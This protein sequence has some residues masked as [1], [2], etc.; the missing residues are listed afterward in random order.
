MLNFNLFSSSRSSREL[1]ACN[2]VSDKDGVDSPVYDHMHLPGQG[3]KKKKKRRHRTIFT[4]YQLDE[5]EKAFKDAHYPDVQTREILAMKTSLPEDRIQVWFQNR[6]AKWRKTEKT[7][8]RSSIMAE[9]G[10]YGAMVRHSLPLPETIVKSAKEGVLESSAPWLLSMY[11]K[12]IE[13]TGSK[14]ND[15]NTDSQDP[16][17]D[18]GSGGEQEGRKPEDFRSESIAALRARAMEYTAKNFPPSSDAGD[19]VIDSDDMSS[20][21]ERSCDSNASHSLHKDMTSLD[22]KTSSVYNS[23]P[24]SK[25][26]HLAN[27]DASND[28]EPSTRTPESYKPAHVLPNNKKAPRDSRLERNLSSP[29]SPL[30]SYKETHTSGNKTYSPVHASVDNSRS[31]NK[32]TS[33]RQDNHVL[34]THPSKS[35]MSQFGNTYLYPPRSSPGRSSSRANLMS[36][37]SLFP[38]PYS[39][40]GGQFSPTNTTSSSPLPNKSLHLP[41]NFS[42]PGWGNPF[43]SIF[44]RLGQ[45]QLKANPFLNTYGFSQLDKASLHGYR[46]PLTSGGGQMVAPD[47]EDPSMGVNSVIAL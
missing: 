2:D 8:G 11:R 24:S 20:D 44:P 22:E 9:Y 28:L 23:I 39:Y 32:V 5:L 37:T 14:S 33:G 6:R 31:S 16:D 29:A 40:L 30:L 27:T 10:L 7:W 43:S 41:L 21:D 3:K 46:S 13:S 47:G 18:R 19:D 35:P 26:G 25:S 34:S 45:D 38:S 17:Q 42:N 4:S 36:T 15:T 12:S 1:F